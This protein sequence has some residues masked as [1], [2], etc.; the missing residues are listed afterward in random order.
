VRYR[1]VHQNQI[2][3]DDGN[4]AFSIPPKAEFDAREEAPGIKRLLRLGWI[5]RVR[6][7]GLLDGPLLV[8][9]DD[10]E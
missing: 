10:E 5:K 9:I 7:Q 2:A 6:Q 1:N 4:A 8:F 3:V